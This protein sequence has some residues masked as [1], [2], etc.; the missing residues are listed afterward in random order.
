[1]KDPV[2][3][4]KIRVF[5]LKSFFVLIWLGC[6]CIFKNNFLNRTAD[7][8]INI[9]PKQVF[10]FISRNRAFFLEKSFKI[11]VAF[12]LSKE[13]TCVVGSILSYTYHP[14]VDTLTNKMRSF[15][16]F[17][18]TFYSF[19]SSDT[20][21]S[22]KWSCLPKIIFRGYFDKHCFVRKNCLMKNIM[23]FVTRRPL[24]IKTLISSH[25]N[26]FS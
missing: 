23:N 9:S 15:W 11:Y 12:Y 24:P 14:I 10:A 17:F 22:Q 25:K 13:S 2:N 19:L 21:L 4:V 26:D 3:I 1:M 16:A 18:V 8:G 5:S 6:Y 20:L 7:V